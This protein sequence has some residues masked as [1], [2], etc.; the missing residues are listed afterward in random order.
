MAVRIV[1]DE[2]IQRVSKVLLQYWKEH[3]WE[4]TMMRLEEY[5]YPSPNRVINRR[6]VDP[7][8]ILMND[9]VFCLEE[10][11]MHPRDS[12]LMVIRA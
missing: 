6:V 4:D 12:L 9:V 7:A 3:G 11:E 1:K 8:R 2:D 10:M 5:A